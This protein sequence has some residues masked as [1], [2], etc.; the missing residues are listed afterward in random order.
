MFNFIQAMMKCWKLSSLQ[1]NK[2]DQ[3]VN[4]IFRE[5]ARLPLGPDLKASDENNYSIFNSVLSSE[6]AFVSL[7]LRLVCFRLSSNQPNQPTESEAQANSGE[8]ELLHRKRLPFLWVQIW[9]TQRCVGIFEVW[10]LTLI[11][12]SF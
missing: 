7:R 12:I 5:A 9:L 8:I 2:I 11:F 10:I 1:T 4:I 3:K 6:F